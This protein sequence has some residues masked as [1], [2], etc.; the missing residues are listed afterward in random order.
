MLARVVIG[1]NS[2]LPLNGSPK[3]RP[4]LDL[5]IEC[6][7]GGS[8]LSKARDRVERSGKVGRGRMSEAS[9]SSVDVNAVAGGGGMS[10]RGTDVASAKVC[11]C[12]ST[13]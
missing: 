6:L 9:I 5:A 1:V 3:S 12:L 13:I 8:G 10:S 4:V 2:K 7:E 11:W